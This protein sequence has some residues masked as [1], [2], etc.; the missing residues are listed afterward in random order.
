L[1]GLALALTTIGILTLGGIGSSA[2]SF[3]N[4]QIVFLLIGL[5]VMLLIANLDYRLFRNY[6]SVVLGIYFVAV[7]LL[8]VVLQFNEIRAVRSWIFIAGFQFEPSELAKLGVIIVLAKYFSQKHIE[9]HQ[10]RHIIV[11]FLYIILP[12]GLILLQPDL[13][14]AAIFFIIWLAIIMAIGVPRRHLVAILI[15]GAIVVTIGWVGFLQ[16]YQKSRIIS[17]LDPLTDPQGAG[18]STIQSRIAIGAGGFWG[19]G[20]GRGTQS[21]GGF[22]PEAHTDF[23]FAAFAE[24]FGLIGILALMALLFLLIFRVAQITQR[25]NNN[26]A[27]L[28]GLGFIVLIAAHAL[29]SMGINIGLLPVTGI[30]FSFLS[31][32]GSHLVI[33]MTGLGLVQSIKIH[34]SYA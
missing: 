33:L 25:A 3:F 5:G 4:R 8:L 11:S 28:F 17:F 24:Q 13:G 31:Y 10:I 9:A 1:F 20:W 21:T 19:A 14:S 6:S 22:L 32:G 26:F 12:A 34:S 30:P 27:K 15:L 16:D 18:Y 29:L 7:I 2:Q 23:I